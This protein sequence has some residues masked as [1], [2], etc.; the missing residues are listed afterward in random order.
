MKEMNNYKIKSLL[1]ERYLIG[2]VTPDKKQFFIEYED[3]HDNVEGPCYDIVATK[4]SQSATIFYNREKVFEVMKKM[5]ET[6]K[7]KDGYTYQFISANYY[8]NLSYVTYTSETL[9]GC[10]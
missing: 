4:F 3:Y 6:Y 7:F 8:G 10:V 2:V 9:I 5:T 1:P